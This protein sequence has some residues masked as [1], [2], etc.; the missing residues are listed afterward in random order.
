MHVLHCISCSMEFL[1]ASAAKLSNS[2][3]E[4]TNKQKK[5]LL[6]ADL[7]ITALRSILAKSFIP[8][9]SMNSEGDLQEFLSQ[10][11]DKNTG[12]WP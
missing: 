2:S 12:S 1:T 7:S 10:S 3:G 8:Q 6:Y 9:A 4:K 11:G 5:Q